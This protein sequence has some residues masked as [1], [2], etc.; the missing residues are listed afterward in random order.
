M[1]SVCGQ[2]D[3][4]GATLRQRLELHLTGG[5]KAEEKQFSL[6]NRNGSCAAACFGFQACF[7]GNFD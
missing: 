6:K 2:L 4:H 1:Q 3:M 5:P 7:M